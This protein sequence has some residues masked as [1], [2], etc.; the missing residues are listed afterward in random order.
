MKKF[1]LIICGL[2]ISSTVSA[3]AY[4]R[5]HFADPNYVT[6]NSHVGIDVKSITPQDN[7]SYYVVLFN[8]NSNHGNDVITNSFEWY[9]S[10]KGKRV[11][12]YFSSLIPARKYENKTVWVWPDEVPKGYENYV[13][14]QFGREPRVKDR[15]DDD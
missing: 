9:L 12:E 15:R 4:Q 11:S 10:Y 7:G 3:Q 13:T 14:I 2:L 6:N 5:L 1:L 8:S